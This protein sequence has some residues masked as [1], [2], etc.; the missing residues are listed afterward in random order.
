MTGLVYIVNLLTEI[1]FP[2]ASQ[3]LLAA[4]RMSFL[5]DC[6]GY[7]FGSQA[8]PGFYTFSNTKV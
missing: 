3:S 5:F 7:V 1:P 4:R 8:F 6:Q 2:T